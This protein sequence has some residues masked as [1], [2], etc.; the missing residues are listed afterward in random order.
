MA[1]MEEIVKRLQ[2]IE[3]ALD[4]EKA[5]RLKLEEELQTAKQRGQQMEEELQQERE[6]T[7]QTTLNEYLR[8]CHEYLSETISVQTNKALCT[9][10]DPSNAKGKV[11]PDFLKP[12]EGFINTQK[13]TLGSLYAVYQS[14]DMLQ[15]FDNRNY[16]KI[17]GEKVAAQKLSSEQELVNNQRDTVE[18]PVTAIIAHL[19]SQDGVRK[20]LGLEGGVE[21]YNHL[22]PLNE[23]AREL[24]QKLEAQQVLEPSTPRRLPPSISH[25]RPDQVCVYTTFDNGIQPTLVV[26]YKAPHKVTCDH[27]LHVLRHDRHPTELEKVING[28]D[29]PPSQDIQGHFEYYTER[30]VAA[31]ITQTFSYMVGCGTEYGYISTGEA[32][33]FLHI[34]PEEDAKTVYFHLA[35][36]NADVKA[37]KEDF[38]CTDNYLNRTTISQVLAFS[39]RAINSVQ[40]PHE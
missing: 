15:C 25:C 6:E 19:K 20:E 17:Q 11:R 16:I 33:I 22:N 8:L 2:A 27:L 34:K 5:K 21:F 14:D 23:N 39:L 4:E 31:V 10:G 32:F 35:V 28:L 13:E 1:D 12:W 3:Q 30:M 40:Q 26:E 36:P 9:Q 38:P 18:T 7:R 24:A 37:Q 29:P